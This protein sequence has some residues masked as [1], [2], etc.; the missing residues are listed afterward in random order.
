MS[1]VEV[2]HLTVAYDKQPVLIDASLTVEE[3]TLT[4]VLGPSGC[5]KTTLLRAV[6]GFEPARSGTISIGGKVVDDSSKRLAPERRH[7]G[8]VPQEGAL[9]PHL[10]VGA[11]VGFAIGGPNRA[12]RLDRDRRVLELLDLVG[13]AELVDRMPHQLSGGQQQRVS[14]ARALASDPTVVLLDEPFASLDAALRDRLRHDIRDVLRAAGTTAILVTHDRAEAL[15]LGD[16]VAIMRDG[17]IIQAGPPRELYRLPV[18]LGVATFVGEA[19]VLHAVVDPTRPTFASTVLGEMTLLHPAAADCQVVV[20][21]EQVCVRRLDA[22]TTASSAER[23][24]GAGGG[25]AAEFAGGAAGVGH[26]TVRR[27]EYYGHDARVDIDLDATFTDVHGESFDANDRVAG[28]S[29]ERRGGPVR[30]IARV[31]GSQSWAG[32]DRVVL[33]VDS[34]VWPLP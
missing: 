2:E 29:D 16:Q 30:V 1:A 19:T 20:R 18:D 13:M 12:A 23:A 10:T 25:A 24:G 17:K 26:G 34:P 33:H 3:G 14:V 7:V 28:E 21:P 27:V 15:S 31:A 11:N 9:F 6:A 32:G 22:I 5:G 4:C 8:Y